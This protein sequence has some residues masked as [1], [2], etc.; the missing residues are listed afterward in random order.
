[1][2]VGSLMRNLNLK[3]PYCELVK[4]KNVP[5]LLSQGIL[6]FLMNFLAIF[7]INFKLLILLFFYFFEFLFIFQELLVRIYVIFW[8]DP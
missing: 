6:I 5:Y 3:A 4:V 2:A 8:R 7:I 1:M